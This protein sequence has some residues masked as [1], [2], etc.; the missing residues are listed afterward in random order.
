MNPVRR[1]YTLAHAIRRLLHLLLPA[2][3]VAL[4]TSPAQSQVGSLR[5]G[6][7][8]RVTTPSVKGLT[9]IVKSAGADSVVIFTE[10]SAA[11]LALPT[12]DITRVDVSQGRSIGAGARRGAIWGGAIGGVLG[13]VAAAAVS[14]D[15][16]YCPSCE[17]AAAFAAQSLLGGVIWGAGIG[18]FV[19]AEKWETVSMHP[20][21]GASATGVRLGFDFHSALLH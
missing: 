9:G 12:S 4:A 3:A 19:K 14:A 5:E 18:A 13:I 6:M 15:D 21:V 16:S 8:V 20:R 2:V 17:G 1:Q 11:R 10:G 7:R